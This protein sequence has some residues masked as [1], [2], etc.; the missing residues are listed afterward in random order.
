MRWRA[1]GVTLALAGCLA[2]RDGASGRQGDTVVVAHFGDST[3]ITDYLPHERRV[4]ALLNAR[5]VARYPRQRIVS[6]NVARSGE[7]IRQ[8]LDGGR[9]ERDV[10]QRIPHID[11]ALVR[12]GQNDLKLFSPEEFKVQVAELCDRLRRDYPGVHLV[13]ETNTYVD[14]AHGGSE[15]MDLQYNRYWDVYRQLARERGY[16]LVDVFARRRRE[17]E[18]GNWDQNRRN[19]KLASERF[20]HM[21]LDGEKDAEMAGVRGWFS[22]THPNARAVELIADEEFRVL[23]AT[24]PE[25]LPQAD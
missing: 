7:Y 24:W 11:V 8:F 18:A 10:R 14:P 17:T 21:I 25:A 6:H 22:D 9:Y 2:G 3:C 16:P 5:L 4:D 19:P 1:L 15:K 13:L 20:G 12:Y 23:T